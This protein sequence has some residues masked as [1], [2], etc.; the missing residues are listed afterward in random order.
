MLGAAGL[1]EFVD[2]ELN[3]L[4]LVALLPVVELFPK[5]ELLPNGLLVPFWFCCICC[6]TFC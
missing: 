2:P 4:E 3:G 5:A 1:P 6:C